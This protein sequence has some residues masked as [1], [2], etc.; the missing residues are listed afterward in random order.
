VI[1]VGLVL[2]VAPKLEVGSG[3]V[4]GAERTADLVVLDCHFEAPPPPIP[5]ENVVGVGKTDGRA[6]VEVAAGAGPL[7]KVGLAE[8]PISAKISS[9]FGFGGA[10]AGALRFGDASLV[11]VGAGKVGFAEDGGDLVGDEG[12]LLVLLPPKTDR[13]LDPDPRCV[14]RFFW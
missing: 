4:C 6:A 13:S 5:P 3:A 2:V 9:C 8:K 11:M 14:N 7:V 12:G 1:V 10:G